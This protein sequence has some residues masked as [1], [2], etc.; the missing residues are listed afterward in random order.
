[1]MF[2]LLLTEKSLQARCGKEAADVVS[3]QLYTVRRDLAYLDRAE[4]RSDDAKR[5]LLGLIRERPLRA[6]LYVDLL[7]CVIPCR[8]RPSGD[9]E[10]P[11]GRPTD[12][13]A[14][15]L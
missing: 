14:P 12:R 10:R 8:R 3:N 7:K 11:A 6:E 4:G 2:E 15:R 13:D 5:Q 1:M 9:V